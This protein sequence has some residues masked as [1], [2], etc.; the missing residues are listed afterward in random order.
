MAYKEQEIID[1]AVDKGILGTNGRGTP[2]AQHRKTLEEVRELTD[3]L[4]TRNMEEIQDAIGD[5]YV[6]L[7]IQAAMQGLSMDWCIDTAY[8]VI[9]KRTGKMVNGQFVKDAK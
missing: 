6:T 1:W 4:V 8:G 3:A 2:E 9:S 7:V 5:I